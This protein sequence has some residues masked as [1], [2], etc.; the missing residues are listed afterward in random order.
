M[1]GAI[2]IHFAKLRGRKLAA[3]ITIVLSILVLA[4]PAFLI[5]CKNIDIAG[6]TIPYINGLVV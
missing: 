4:T 1:C 2:V 5:H 6:I 3:F